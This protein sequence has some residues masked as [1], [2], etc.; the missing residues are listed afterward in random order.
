MKVSVITACYNSASTI[1]DTLRSV[2]G[3]DYPGIE[4]IIVDGESKDDTLAIVDR[5]RDKIAQIVSGKDGGIYF[6]LNKGISL[7]T[8]DIIALLHSDDFYA[9][10]GVISRVV[11]C[12]REKQ[13]DSVYGDL[14]YVDAADTKKVVRTWISGEYVHGKFRKGWMP[15]HPAFFLKRECYLQSGLFNTSF[16]TAADYELMLRMLH[17]EK[18]STAYLPGVLVKMRTGGASNV[19]LKARINANREDRRAWTIN[20]LKPGPLTLLRKP[21]SK[22]GQFLKRG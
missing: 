16:K 14:Q 5:Y 13:T 18:R 17:K 19:T 6:A 9:D 10:N 15:P 3:Q 1:E 4:Y 7:A 2:T 12:F 21:L 22:L 20:G 11:N 8:G